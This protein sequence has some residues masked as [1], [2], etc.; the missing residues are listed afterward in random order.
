MNK[1]ERK[2]IIIVTG[3]FPPEIGGPATLAPEFARRLAQRDFDVTVITYSNTDLDHLDSNANYKI[4][5]IK[6]RNKISNY[7][8]FFLALLKESRNANAMYSFDWFSAGFP[9]ALTSKILRVPFVVRVGGGYIWEKYLAEGK[10]PLSLFDFYKQGI[11]KTYPVMFRIIQFVF[12]CARVV[13]FNSEKQRQ[14]YEKYYAIPH[15]KT[16]CIE[17]PRSS[18][19]LDITRDV[20]RIQ[21][22][23]VFAGR[24]IV[25]KNIETLIKAFSGVSHIY[26]LTLIGEG[27]CETDLRRLVKELKLEDRVQFL[28]PMS[29]FDLYRRVIQSKFLV[30]PSW[31]DVSPNQVFEA[32]SLHVPVLLTKEHFLPLD[33]SQCRTIDPYSVDS[34]RETLI[35]LSREDMYQDFVQAWEH[36]SLAEYT[37]E[38]FYNKNLDYLNSIML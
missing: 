15:H 7:L 26:T 27:P 23:I 34:L 16:A 2:K 24:F 18:L 8:R 6:R 13:V 3:I 28:P 32:I 10:K 31:T 22:E 29:Q 30:L 33:T 36:V 4:V 1:N 19:Q 37:W 21:N 12:S 17:N 9:V 35:E 14:I 5:R 25:M 38:S 11:Y 20:S